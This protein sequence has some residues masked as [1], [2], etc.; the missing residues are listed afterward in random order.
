MAPEDVITPLAATAP[1]LPETIRPVTFGP[2]L[3]RALVAAQKAAKAVAKDAENTFHR[4]KYASAEAIVDEARGALSDN[5][6][7]VM[8]LSVKRDPDQP[9]HVWETGEDEKTGKPTSWIVTP[10]RILSTYRLLH[11]SGQWQDFEM[12]TPVI[13]EK[14]RPEDKAEF[15]SRTENLGYAMRD[16][17]LIPRGTEGANVPSGRDDTDKDVRGPTNRQQSREAQPTDLERKQ[18]N[19]SRLMTAKGDDGLGWSIAG[20][21]GWSKRYFGVEQP[22]QMTDQQVTDA[23]SLALALYE[24]RTK[25]P[26]GKFEVNETEYRKLLAELQAAGRVLTPEEPPAAAKK[27]KAA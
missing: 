3:A 10:R 19:L 11:E 7:A 20:C 18:T 2:E 21:T 26:E 27:G 13:P 22:G 23:S 25:T 17:L 12:S 6:L 8:P 24:H 15:G 4:Y 1:R 5:G 14:G 9:D 16:L